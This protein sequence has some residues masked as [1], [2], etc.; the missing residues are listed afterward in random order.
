MEFPFDKLADAP[1]PILFLIVIALAVITAGLV[2]LFSRWKKPTLLIF[3]NENGRVEISRAAIQKVVQRTC[4]RF[5]EVGRA[6][7]YLSQSKGYMHIKVRLMLGVKTR[8]PDIS[9]HLQK[10]ITRAV[11]D[12]LGIKTLADVTVV[13]EGFMNPVEQEKN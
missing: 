13:V 1:V 8:V 9:S 3:N 10:Q 6:R 12:D 4:E 7:S 5:I 11:R 2:M